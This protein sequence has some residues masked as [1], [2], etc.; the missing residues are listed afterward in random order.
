MASDCCLKEH[1]GQF[2]NACR[3]V[4]ADA[5]QDVDQTGVGR[6]VQAAS[7]DQALSDTNVLGR[8]ARSG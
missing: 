4:L 2:A 7:A 6:T 1:G 8:P 5:L 3:R